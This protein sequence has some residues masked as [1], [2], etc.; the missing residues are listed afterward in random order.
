M[1]F[2]LSMPDCAEMDLIRMVAEKYEINWEE[3]VKLLVRRASP[4]IASE[5]GLMLIQPDTNR[6]L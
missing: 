2:R 5:L 3:A 4:V 6:N 1:R